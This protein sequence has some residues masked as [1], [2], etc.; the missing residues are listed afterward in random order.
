MNIPTRTK[1]RNSF[2]G[3]CMLVD[4][5]FGHNIVRNNPLLWRLLC[6]STQE[7]NK[8]KH[9]SSNKKEVTRERAIFHNITCVIC[10]SPTAKKT[11]LQHIS[12]NKGAMITFSGINPDANLK[13]PQ[14]VKPAQTKKTEP[15]R[16]PLTTSPH[17][18]GL[19]MRNN[20][21]KGD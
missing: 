13:K 18:S 12:P 7:K 20:H 15:P 5:V 10:Q 19:F 3:P 17:K 2:G 11:R 8:A 4:W 14:I 6:G 1:K 21:T 16:I 9:R